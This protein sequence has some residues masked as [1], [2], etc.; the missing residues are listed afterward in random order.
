MVLNCIFFSS[1]LP[2]SFPPYSYYTWR[3]QSQIN[4]CS[5]SQTCS[6][7]KRKEASVGLTIF[8][9]CGEKLQSKTN[10]EAMSALFLSAVF[11][12]TMG[13][14]CAFVPQ[15]ITRERL[16]QRW[17]YI[18]RG[19]PMGAN[20][21][22]RGDRSATYFHLSS[23]RPYFIH[24]RCLK[25]VL[26]PLG[27]RKPQ[28]RKHCRRTVRSGNI[29]E[30]NSEQ[31]LSMSKTQ[32]KLYFR[33]GMLLWIRASLTSFRF[34]GNWNA[35]EHCGKFVRRRGT[36]VNKVLWE[37]TPCYNLGRN[38]FFPDSRQEVY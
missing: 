14:D 23:V 16:K 38:C 15:T 4:V 5:A 32:W 30:R 36:A 28:Y 26:W 7:L 29:S 10:K 31:N 8:V 27:V 22:L 1:Y 25:Y 13:W 24:V 37:V 2:S 17:N 6:L 35:V 18:D 33:F 12:I 11:T 9:I 20:L 34:Y 21:G 3:L 19:N